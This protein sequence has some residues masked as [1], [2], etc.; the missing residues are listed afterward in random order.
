MPSKDG[1]YIVQMDILWSLVILEIEKCLIM[2]EDNQQFITC[3]DL[4]L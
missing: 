2:V 1:M 4:L 3:N